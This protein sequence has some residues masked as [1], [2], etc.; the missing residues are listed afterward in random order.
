LLNDDNTILG[1]ENIIIGK[2]KAIFFVVIKAPGPE[3]KA[4]KS[5]FIFMS[6]QWSAGQIT[7]QIH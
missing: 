4:Q 6:V 2:R 1:D 5:E 3:V 7:T